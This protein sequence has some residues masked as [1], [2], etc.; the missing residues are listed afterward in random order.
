MAHCHCRPGLRP[1][2]CLWHFGLLSKVKRR[3]V[4]RLL[5]IR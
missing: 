4:K 5:G 1:V 3:G 2:P